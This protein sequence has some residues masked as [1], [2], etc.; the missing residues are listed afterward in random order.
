MIPAIAGAV[1]FGFSTLLLV[2]LGVNCAGPAPTGPADPPTAPATRPLVL[3]NVN[4]IGMTTAQVARGRTV[5]IVDGRIAAIGD[6]TISRPPGALVIEGAGRYLM[7][8]LID[9]HVHIRTG[10]VEKY[11]GAGVTTVRNMWG[12]RG[13]AALARRIEDGEVAG[14]RIVS[15]SPGLDGEP[16]QWPET[17]FV[18]RPDQA[19]AAVAEQVAAGWR[20]IKVYTSLTLPAYE[21]IVAEA[22]QAGI[23]VVGHVPAAVPIETA[24]GLGQHSIEHLTGYDARVNPGRSGTWAWIAPDPSRYESLARL[25]KDAGAWNCPT[26]AIYSA[27]AKQHRAGERQA[28]IAQ[29]RAFVGALHRAG[30]RLLAGSDA[31]IDVV[32]PGESLHDEL[33]E[34][35][36]AGLSPY[37]ALRAA[38]VDAGAFL[39]IEGLGTAVVGAPADL[40]LVTGNPLEHVDRIRTFDGLIHRGAWIPAG[41]RLTLRLGVLDGRASGNP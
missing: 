2:A 41:R 18:L 9:M 23:G 29:R 7:P 11:P 32:A 3:Q 40:L 16:A 35:V 37:Q 14:P 17:R 34:L 24:L 15:A 21:A 31:G 25:T 30:A 5:I 19:A 4:V 28:I 39:E 38:T 12:W 1:R 36:A 10:D 22:K 8:S 6:A 33:F 13:L 26:L 20:W 27:L